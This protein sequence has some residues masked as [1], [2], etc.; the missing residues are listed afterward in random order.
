[1]CEAYTTTAMVK[2]ENQLIENAEIVLINPLYPPV[3]GDFSSWGTPPDPRRK[4]PAPLFQQ[5]LIEE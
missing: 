2:K 3:L 4:Y 1:M 5:F